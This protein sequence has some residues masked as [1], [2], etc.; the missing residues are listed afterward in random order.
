MDPAEY[1]NMGEHYA[2]KNGIDG[3]LDIYGGN[4]QHGIIRP[5]NRDFIFIIQN[6]TDREHDDEWQDNILFYY[7]A[8]RKGDQKLDKVVGNAYLAE[9]ITNGE[10]IFLFNYCGPRDYEYAGEVILVIEPFFEYIPNEGRKKLVFP[11]V[12]KEYFDSIGDS[13]EY[14]E[15]LLKITSRM[16]NDV[17]KERSHAPGLELVRKVQSISSAYYRDPYVRFCVLSRANGVCELCNKPGP[18]DRGDG[19]M[20]LES[21]HVIPL[22]DGGDDSINNAVGLC[23]NCHRK[24]HH[25]MLSDDVD[26]LLSRAKKS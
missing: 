1:L 14:N 24:M 6:E 25:L 22:S 20:F 16:P 8:G 19:V 13:A 2:L 9:T 10:R 26:Y 18:F 15:M 12:K 21:H 5:K 7:G 11:L 17:V 3:I 4:Q 23:P